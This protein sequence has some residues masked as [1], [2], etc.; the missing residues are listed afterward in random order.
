MVSYARHVKEGSGMPTV[1]VGLLTEPAQ[2]EA[3][4]ATGDADM[5][6]IAREALDDPNRVHHARMHL[7]RVEDPY[8]EWPVQKGFAVRNKDRSLKIRG[9]AET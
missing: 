5:E 2:A 8:E 1:A 9:F 4:I 3:I 6:A 7:G